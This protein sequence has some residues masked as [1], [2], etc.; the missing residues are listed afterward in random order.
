MDY[1][2]IAHKEDGNFLG[3][4]L[5]CECGVRVLQQFGCRVEGPAVTVETAGEDLLENM[6]P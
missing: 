6:P 3:G 1:Q 5:W 2:G 4:G